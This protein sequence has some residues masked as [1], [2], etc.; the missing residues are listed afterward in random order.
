MRHAM[1]VAA[2]TLSIGLVSTVARAGDPTESLVDSRVI[3]GLERVVSF[4]TYESASVTPNGSSST[5]TV[6]VTGLSLAANDPASASDVFYTVPRLGVD[7]VLGAHFTLGGAFFAWTDVS[8]SVSVSG[9]NVTAPSQDQPKRTYWGI[10]PRL[11]YI[12][13]VSPII[14][15]WP[16]AGIEYHN[17]NQ[18][19]INE[20]GTT[21]GGGSLQQLAMDLEG[22]LVIA[23]Y[24]HI[25]FVVTVYGAIP[26]S[27]SISNLSETVA[28]TSTSSVTGSVAETA[29]GLTAGMV[30]FF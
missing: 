11:G 17:L 2:A 9:G 28:G 27:G 14:A 8:S 13:N 5:G 15:L 7:A 22:N 4:V 21:V 18:S 10:A 20:N 3:V 26:I 19:T 6:S 30:G 25:G 12:V 16:R 1:I 29:V 23:P 24:D